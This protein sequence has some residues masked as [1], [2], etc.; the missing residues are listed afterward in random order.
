[1][2]RRKQSDALYARH[3]YHPVTGELN[4]NYKRHGGKSG[5]S[6]KNRNATQAANFVA[7]DGEG[8]NVNGKHEYTML[9]NSRGDEIIDPNGLSTYDCL[10]FLLQ[11]AKKYPSN[12]RH[13][14]YSANYDVNMMLRD[15]SRDDLQTLWKTGHVNWR[16]IRIAYRHR[17]ELTLKLPRV[18]PVTGKPVW[19]EYSQ[20]GEKKYKPVYLATIT[21][22]DVIGFFQ[23]PFVQTLK[24]NLNV[25][26]SALVNMQGMK[27]KRSDFTV[28]EIQDI[29]RY[30][31]TE[32]E[33]L[34]L[35]MTD[36]V[37]KLRHPDVDLTLSRWDGAGAVA[38]AIYQKHRTKQYMDTETHKIRGTRIP[39]HLNQALADVGMPSVNEAAQFAYSGGRIENPLYGYYDNAV[40]HYDI[41]SAY[42]SAIRS[43]PCLNTSVCGN[44]WR[45]VNEY[46]P[47]SYGIWLIRWDYRGVVDDIPIMPFFFRS[48]TG[49]I[50][51]PPV[52]AGMYWTPDV[53]A[54]LETMPRDML[55]IAG[56]WVL[57]RRCDH[58][59]FSFVQN[60]FNARARL[61]REKDGAQ[62]VLKLGLNSLYGKMIQQVGSNFKGEAVKPPFHQLEWAGYITSKTRSMIY[63]AAMQSP[64]DIICMMTDG[65]YSR[66]PLQLDCGDQLGQWEDAIHSSML[67]VQAGVYYVQNDSTWNTIKL[68]GFDSDTFPTVDKIRRAYA[69]GVRSLRLASTRF[70]GMGSALSSDT[71]YEQ[72][73]QWP[74]RSRELRLYPEPGTGKRYEI[75]RSTPDD[76]PGNRLFVTKPYYR[77]DCV[78]TLSTPYALKWS[79]AYDNEC[80]NPDGISNRV[81]D[82]EH[83]A[84]AYE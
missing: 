84:T 25:P 5:H 45:W 22:W 50:Y 19:K 21:L 29:R 28:D 66:V 44:E 76:N 73:R 17:K 55:H 32:V 83:D 69:S 15:L 78:D 43:L 60:M 71:L 80:P 68:R 23:G 41:V 64:R 52:G 24:T 48:N 11:C 30:C 74:T 3:K 61:K 65:I 51:Y 10:M 53:D 33:Y 4:T 67:C 81:Y 39:P 36:L 38:A 42:P 12:A 16:G 20:N 49:N 47:E 79:N 26:D 1:M 14:C 63:R 31:R 34:E 57:R 75:E 72:W 7:W 27:G 56:G 70:I 35:L 46:E 9:I 6:G 77:P 8:W 82:D 37:R 2:P 58:E 54:A 40:H 59:P 62:L 13:V 18:N